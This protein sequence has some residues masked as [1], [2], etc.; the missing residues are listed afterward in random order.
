MQHYVWLL[1]LH[2]ELALCPKAKG[3]NRVLDIG[4]GTG[5]WAIEYGRLRIWLVGNPPMRIRTL[6]GACA[7]PI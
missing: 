4:T 5:V 1:T 3:A 7:A 6:T 2:G